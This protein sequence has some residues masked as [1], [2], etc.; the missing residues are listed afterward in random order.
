MNNHSIID[1]NY[2]RQFYF[3]QGNAFTRNTLSESRLSNKITIKNLNEIDND[4]FPSSKGNIYIKKFIKYYIK[5]KYSIENRSKYYKYIFNKLK[6]INELSC[7]EPKK[8]Y[9][10]NKLYNGYSILN[11][12]N[13]EKQIGTNSRYGSIYITSIKK[14]LG[15]YP[16]ASKVMKINKSNSFENEVNNIITNNILSK[17]LS[18]H[19]VFTY[20]SFMCTKVKENVP[21]IIKNELYYIILNELAHG[22]LKQLVKMKTFVTDDLLIYNVLIQTILS[23]MSF[24]YMGYSHNDCHYGNFLYHRNKE[25]GYYHYKINGVSYYLKSCK[26]NIMIFDFGFSKKINMDNLNNNMIEDYLIIFHAFPNKKKLKEAW[27]YYPKYPS[28]EFSDYVIYL[29]NRLEGLTRADLTKMKNID[30][31]VTD[32]ILPRLE[33]APEKI[34]TKIKPKCKILNKSPFIIDKFLHNSLFT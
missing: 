30:T 28:D 1:S 14:T 24:H 2:H 4:D 10:G 26:Y 13:L 25:E 11:T 5:N 21:K 32:I 19:F 8:F 20:K 15:K 6:N 12:I 33:E 27:A 34:F 23:I 29:K 31:L 18:K 7:L 16:I 22:D 9:R 3:Q 17:R